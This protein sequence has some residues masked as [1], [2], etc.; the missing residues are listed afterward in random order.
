MKADRALSCSISIIIPRW[1]KKRDGE[2]KDEKRDQGGRVAQHTWTSSYQLFM[3]KGAHP[4]YVYDLYL[5]SSNR[6]R[7]TRCGFGDKK[8]L[9]SLRSNMCVETNKNIRFLLFLSI[10]IN[11]S[12]SSRHMCTG[13][14]VLLSPKCL[15]HF[16][17][18]ENANESWSIALSLPWRVI[19]VR[20]KVVHS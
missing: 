20:P 5:H 12:S 4:A 15:C 3:K 11:I 6:E 14:N 2:E 7:D 10:H 19:C 8:R 18:M 16:H 13:K 17:E 1:V 9:Y